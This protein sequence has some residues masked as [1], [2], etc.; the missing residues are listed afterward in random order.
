[1]DHRV[2]EVDGVQICAAKWCNNNVIKP[3]P[4]SKNRPFRKKH[5]N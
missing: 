4:P 1:M 2:A 5:Q 3:P